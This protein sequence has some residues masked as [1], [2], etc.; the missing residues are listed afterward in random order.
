M[1]TKIEATNG[2]KPTL[3]ITAKGPRGSAREFRAA[4]YRLAAQIEETTPKDAA[5]AM[6][7]AGESFE[8]WG[9]ADQTTFS[10]TIRVETLTGSDAEKR[11][12]SAHLARFASA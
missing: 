3:K 4:V 12:A 1:N 9:P 7:I 2:T 11:A 5:W 6:E 10:A 8:C